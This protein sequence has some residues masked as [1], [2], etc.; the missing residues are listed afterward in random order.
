MH[1]L[2]FPS[3]VLLFPGDD[4]MNALA[5]YQFY[6]LYSTT[7]GYRRAYKFTKQ[8]RDS[9]SNFQGI[10]MQIARY[11]KRNVGDKLS[12]NKDV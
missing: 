3:H 4:V 6:R 5:N 7:K 11:Y 10:K 1:V 12:E 9:N 8:F 2:L